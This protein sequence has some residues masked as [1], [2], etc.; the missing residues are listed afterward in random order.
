MEAP[1]L[2]SAAYDADTIPTTIDTVRPPAAQ[3]IS[4]PCTT[5]LVEPPR[6]HF[7]PPGAYGQ[8]YRVEQAAV[9]YPGCNGSCRGGM[10][11]S[12]LINIILMLVL[13]YILITGKRA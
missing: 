1:V 2:Q 11:V 8:D 3:V 4:E 6:E 9:P 7:I 5:G 10:R 12:E 13:I